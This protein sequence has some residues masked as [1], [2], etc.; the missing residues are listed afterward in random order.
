MTISLLL[1]SRLN[2][3]PLFFFV[4]SST[5]NERF[6]RERGK[7]RRRGEGGERKKLARSVT[8]DR[9]LYVEINRR[10]IYIAGFTIKN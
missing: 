3:E 5:I 1:L 7:K 8:F 4:R 2:L 9:P 10:E 6:C